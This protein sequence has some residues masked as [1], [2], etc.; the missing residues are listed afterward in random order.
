MNG[1]LIAA[2]GAFGALFGSFAC[3]QVWR[4]RARQLVDD[5]RE[6]EKVDKKEAARLGRLIRPVSHDRSECLSCHRPL[7]WYDLV[8]IV[9]WLSL[10]GHCRYCRAKI[11]YAEV[12]CEVGLALV[13][14]LSYVAWPHTLGTPLQWALF[15]VWLMACVVMCILFVYDAKWSLLPFRINILLICLAAV[16]YGLLFANGFVTSLWSLAG[17][18]VLLGGL[19]LLF[20]VFGWSGMGDGILGIALALLVGRWG[21]AFL[22]LFIA[23]LLGCIMLIPLQ[24]Q[25]KLRRNVKIPFGPFLILA[26]IIGILWGGQLIIAIFGT[27]SAF[28]MALMV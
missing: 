7:A 19:Y 15:A 17:A 5:K 1:I 18:L 14:V 6:G 23:N 11:G 27:S 8:P 10:R 25:K 22:V 3:A 2:L 4:L 28:I 9:S 21:V 20:S 26:T 24:A 12:L 13:F 16:F